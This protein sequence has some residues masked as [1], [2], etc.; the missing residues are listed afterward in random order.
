M[1]MTH[2]MNNT[3]LTVCCCDLFILLALATVIELNKLNGGTALIIVIAI[4]TSSNSSAMTST[5]SPHRYIVVQ[6]RG[7]T[8]VTIMARLHRLDRLLCQPHPECD[9][10]LQ[11]NKRYGL[12]VLLTYV[13]ASACGC[14]AFC[15]SCPEGPSLGK[16]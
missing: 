1:R 13:L 7:R 9:A 15:S 5:T 10:H 3:P 12:L 16:E 2:V 4:M 14:I 6:L 8:I 11:C